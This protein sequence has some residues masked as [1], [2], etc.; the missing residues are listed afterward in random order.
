M[1]DG[2]L[3]PRHNAY[4]KDL[5]LSDNL[6]TQLLRSPSNSRLFNS[7]KPRSL[8]KKIVGLLLQIEDIAQQQTAVRQIIQDLKSVS[9]VSAVCI[10]LRRNIDALDSKLYSSFTSDSHLRYS[11][12][13]FFS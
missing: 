4:T 3:P 5:L 10:V 1:Q 6:V 2:F 8:L 11:S 13:R 12:N 7:V 9:D